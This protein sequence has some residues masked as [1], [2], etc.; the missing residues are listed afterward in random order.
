M[1][2]CINDQG[3][4]IAEEHL[5]RIG[6]PFYSTKQTGTGLGL[7]ITQKIIESHGGTIKISSIINEGTTFSV[8]LPLFL[9][10]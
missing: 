6:E 8:M 1:N 10:E 2:I 3:Y 9:E 5:E 4:G 7:A